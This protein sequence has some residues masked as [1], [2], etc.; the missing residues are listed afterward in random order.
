MACKDK[1]HF[2]Y[3]N[4]LCLNNPTIGPKAS[5]QEERVSQLT[6]LQE[7]HCSGPDFLR[8]Q[9]CLLQVLQDVNDRCEKDHVLLPTATWHL[10]QV[11]QVLQGC[12]HDVSWG[13]KGKR[14]KMVGEAGIL[15]S[16]HSMNTCVPSCFSHVWLFENPWTVAHQAPLFMGFSRQEYWSGLPC[17]LLGD[18]LYPRMEPTSLMS[19]AL[20]GGFFITSTTWEAL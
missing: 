16:Y 11:V 5:V 15:K 19:P 2:R 18:L 7:A 17:P 13:P 20:A 4:S 10:H 12:A 14:E 8:Q 6:Q 1:G 3:Q 9:L